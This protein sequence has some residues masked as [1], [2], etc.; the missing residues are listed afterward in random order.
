VDRAFESHL[1]LKWE[2]DTSLGAYYPVDRATAASERGKFRATAQ[3]GE[4]HEGYA[5][6]SFLPNLGGSGK[7]LIISGTGGATVTAALDFLCDER[8]VSQLRSFLPGN[9][10]SVFPFFESLLKVRSRSGLPRDTNVMII[11]PPQT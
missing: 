2:L 6:I 5:T 8:S 11:R 3:T 1:A 10:T 4:A 9:N 7:V